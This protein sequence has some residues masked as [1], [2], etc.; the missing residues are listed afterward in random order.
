MS[1]DRDVARPRVRAAR[2]RALVAA[3]ALAVSAG[4]ILPTVAAEEA[5]APDPAAT[6]CPWMDTSLPAAERAELLL[7]ASTLEQRMRWLVEQPA[8]QPS[9]T[10]WPGGV[11]YPEQVPCTPD[12]QFANGP[13]GMSG[14]GGTAFPVPIAEASAWDEELSERKGEQ[15]ARE[16]FRAG[17]SVMLAPGMAGGRT[18]L[19]GR[20]PEYYGE[21]PVL[22]GVLAGASASGLEGVPEAPVLANLKH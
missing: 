13:H 1:P 20:T 18:P 11:V 7:D 9:R 12:L 3:T 14:P 16:A 4:G 2:R 10:T 5:D 22:S 21:D 17:R 8:I 19:S 6:E 15:V